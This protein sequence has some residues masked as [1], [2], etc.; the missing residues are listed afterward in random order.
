MNIRA[1]LQKNKTQR[2][3]LYFEMDQKIRTQQGV[4][5]GNKGK[6]MKSICGREHLFLEMDLMIRAKQG[7]GTERNKEK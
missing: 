2:E 4:Q 6:L 3:Q 7:R 1:K 5:K